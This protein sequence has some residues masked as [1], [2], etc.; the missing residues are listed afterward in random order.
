[1]RIRLPLRIYFTCSGD[2]DSRFVCA[3]CTALKNKKKKT[4][5]FSLGILMGA[6]CDVQGGGG[7]LGS[8]VGIYSAL[9][10]KQILIR[11]YPVK[12]DSSLCLESEPVVSDVPVACPISRSFT[13][14][15]EKRR[16]VL[17]KKNG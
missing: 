1:M 13:V 4:G 2:S 14:K 17:K 5:E 6:I 10:L 12:L 11:E 8:E 7:Y 3:I 16:S 9:Q 15:K